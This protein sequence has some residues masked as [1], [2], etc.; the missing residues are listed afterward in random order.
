MKPLIY[1]FILFTQQISLVWNNCPKQM[2]AIPGGNP[3]SCYGVRN[4]NWGVTNMNSALSFCLAGIGFNRKRAF[5]A[6]PKNRDQLRAIIN[7]AKEKNLPS[8]GS[9][10]FWTNY[11]RIQSASDDHLTFEE[12]MAIRQNRSLFINNGIRTVMPDSLW[13]NARQPGN[14]EENDERC[15]AQ[16]NPHTKEIGIDDFQCAGQQEHYVICE[17]SPESK[18]AGYN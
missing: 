15:T 13:R 11:I 16:K 12:Q 17:R 5:L 8:E 3:G 7:W 9:A 1:F 10:G 2:E 14:N 4:F 6:M 18:A